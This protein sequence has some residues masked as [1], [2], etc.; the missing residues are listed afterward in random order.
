MPQRPQPPTR[1]REPRSATLRG[2]ALLLGLITSPVASAAELWDR[3]ESARADGQYA[4]V[5][6]AHR[7][8]VRVLFSELVAWASLGEVPAGAVSRARELGL[9]AERVEDLLILVPAGPEPRAD[10]VFAVRIGVD[11]PPLVLQAPHGWSDLYTGQIVA[12]LFQAGLGRAAFFN[13]AHRGAPSN[14]DLLPVAGPSSSDLAHR[15][16]S[17]FQAATLGAVDGLDRPLVVQVHGFGQG[18]GSFSAVVSPGSSFQPAAEVHR[19]M[20]LL[21]PV[22]GSYGPIADGDIVPE[23]AGVT[24]AQGR[25]IGMDARFLHLEL[26]LSARSVMRQDVALRGELGQA[27]S[28][29]TGAAP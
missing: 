29:L 22:L 3:V 11:V 7:A 12:E 27:L 10:G 15:P 5:Q 1:R 6:A 20:A 4:D 21:E 14:G 28:A 18:H 25:A 23:L 26:N 9:A 24:N 13:S 19:A 8:A 2:L 16:H 17:V